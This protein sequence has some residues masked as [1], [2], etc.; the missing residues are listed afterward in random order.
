MKRPGPK[1]Q[2]LQMR[3][4]Q[5]LTWG[6]V[7]L[8]LLWLLPIMSEFGWHQQTVGLLRDGYRIGLWKV[9]YL[10][11][12]IKAPAEQL[13]KWLVAAFLSWLNPAVWLKACIALFYNDDTKIF[14]GEGE[15]SMGEVN[16]PS[17]DM[18]RW[19]PLKSA[20]QWM[21]AVAIFSVAALLCAAICTCREVLPQLRNAL[22]LS[23]GL[24]TSGAVLA[25]YLRTQDKEFDAFGWAFIFAACLAIITLICALAVE[26]ST[27]H[28]WALVPPKA[29]ATRTRAV[30]GA[31][32]SD[33]QRALEEAEDE[34]DRRLLKIEAGPQAPVLLQALPRIPMQAHTAFAGQPLMVST[35]PLAR[36]MLAPVIT[37]NIGTLPRYNPY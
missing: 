37:A 14:S 3:E 9:L 31:T 36:P 27:R 22:L 24:S 33:A 10:P 21:F 30:T 20:S 32:R 5:V 29:P 16:A 25:Y 18:E 35:L 4:R 1:A 28:L 19:G 8:A 13:T 26:F 23:A 2:A 6:F 17:W 15:Y 7:V 34:E 12:K 11:A